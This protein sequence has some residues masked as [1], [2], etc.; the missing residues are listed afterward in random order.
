MAGGIVPAQTRHLRKAAGRRLGRILGPHP[1][2]QLS[3]AEIFLLSPWAGSRTT[4]ELADKLLKAVGPG[5][6]NHYAE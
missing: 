4:F 2:P 1:Q 3:A 5:A 6:P